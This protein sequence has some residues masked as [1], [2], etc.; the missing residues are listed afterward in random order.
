[1][2]PSTESPK[3]TFRLADQ[4]LFLSGDLTIGH[5][6]VV[7][8]DLEQA[9]QT[10][11][12]NQLVICLDEI[13]H[14][15]SAGVV[16]LGYLE[17]LLRARQVAV[18]I[19][20]GSEAI[21]SIRDGFSVARPIRKS[22]ENEQT[23]LEEIGSQTHRLFTRTLFKFL[24]LVSD[25]FYWALIGPFDKRAHRQ[26]EVTNQ[27]IY[28][29][30]NA[31][32]IVVLISFLMGAVLALQSAVQL[33]QF[34]AGIFVVDLVVI[35]VLREMGPL[36]TAI[37]I[38]GRS[39][40]AIASEIATMVVTEEVDAL[41]TMAINPVRYLV[42]PKFYAAVLMMPFL[43]VMANAAGILGGMTVAYTHLGVSFPMFLARMEEAIFLQDILSGFIKSIV[44]AASIVLTSSFF[45]FQVE[46]GAD[47]VGHMTTAAVVMSIVLII[48]SDSVLALIF[49]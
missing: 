14:L 43:T 40:S 32:P 9:V 36:L 7:W 17:E 47:K 34:G 44:F 3:L 4:T 46:G 5:I 39:G 41:R 45:G 8:P 31:V 12:D 21:Q 30:V 42:V 22:F 15:D 28:I 24:Y 10:Y 1:M 25:I 13:D 48:I 38:A 2:T 27:A 20:G 19:E 23:Y 35:S 29:G 6:E 26:G 18:T 37:M 33:R 11:D 49:Y 16:T